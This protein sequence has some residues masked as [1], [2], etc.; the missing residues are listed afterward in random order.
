M[1]CR[2]G[3]YYCQA[4]P[5][6]GRDGTRL[7]YAMADVDIVIHAAAMMHVDVVEYNP[8]EAVKTNVLGAQH[9][10]KSALHLRWRPS[11]T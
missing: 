10:I 11:S 1:K 3:T 2:I 8:F 7:R 5:G 6:D 9:V 4:L